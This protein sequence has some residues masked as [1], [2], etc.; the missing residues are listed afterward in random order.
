MSR[1][2]NIHNSTSTTTTTTM[3]KQP[4]PAKQ[5]FLLHPSQFLNVRAGRF[6]MTSFAIYITASF[7]FFSSVFYCSKLLPPTKVFYFLIQSQSTAAD[8]Q[9][10]TFFLEYGAYNIQKRSWSQVTLVC[11]CV[12][13]RR[14]ME[15]CCWQNNPSRHIHRTFPSSLFWPR[16]DAGVPCF[17]TVYNNRNNNWK[18]SE[19]ASPSSSW[20][21]SSSFSIISEGTTTA[22]DVLVPRP[23]KKYI[24]RLRHPEQQEFFSFI[25]ETYS[26]ENSFGS[27]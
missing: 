5:L 15:R 21:Q 14:E 4:P 18:T 17:F 22:D 20:L 19:K 1:E 6:F 25:V 9:R 10:Y 13:E 27:F 26:Q 3:R 8:Q 2:K 12:V 7:S 24:S 11:A 23:R 16:G